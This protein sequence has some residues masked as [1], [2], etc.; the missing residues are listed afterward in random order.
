MDLPLNIENIMKMLPHRY[1]F[2]LIDR[3]V[4]L[5]PGERILALKNV[6]HNEPFFK[7]HFPESPIM[8]GVLIIEGMAQ[9]GGVLAFSSQPEETYGTPVYFIGIDKVKFRRP[10]VPGDQL[11]ID[12]RFLK[13][14]SWAVKLAGIATVDEKKVSEAEFV[15]T[16]ERGAGRKFSG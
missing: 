14:S 12:V 15:A 3:V 11:R 7:G 13:K 2:V 1:P 5:V 8:P 16:F 4:E 9:A 6:T 10:V